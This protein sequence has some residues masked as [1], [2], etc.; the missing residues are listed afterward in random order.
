VIKINLLISLIFFVSISNSQTISPNENHIIDYLRFSQ[1]KGTFKSE[2]SFS[3]RPLNLGIG[4]IEIDSSVIN[5]R[6]YSKTILSNGKRL[7]LKILPINYNAEFSSHHPYNR[8]NGSLIPNRGYQHTISPGFFSRIGPL[9]IQLK[10]E[11]LYAQNLDYDGFWDGHYP[12]IWAE[13]YEDWN[14]IDTP[15]RFGDSEYKK[16]LWGQSNIRLNYKKLSLGLSTENIWW[17]PS[18]RN[19]IMMSNHA[20]GF[21]HIT[22]NTLSPINSAIGSFEWQF[23]T[24]KLESSGFNPPQ[25]D[26]TYAGTLLFKEKLNQEGLEDWRYF[27]GFSFTYSPKWIDG[28]SVGFIR[29]VQMYSALVKGNYWWMV[30]NPTYFP[31]FANLFRKNDKSVDYEY[32]TDQAAGIFMRWLWKSAK[33]EIYA[34]FHRNDAPQ[35]FRDLILDSD[36][37]RAITIGLQKIFKSRNNF[38]YL[39]SWEWTQLEQTSGRLLRNAGS[40][41]H[42]I[43]VYHGYTNKGEV[44]GAGIGPG[45]NSNYFSFSAINEKTKYGL[46]F[47][48]IDHDNDFYTEAFMAADDFR[49][50]W[51]DLNL[52]LNYNKKFKNFWLSS[53]LI[54]SRSLNYQWELDDFVEPY[55]HAGRDVNNFHLNIKLSYFL[56]F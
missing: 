12:I 39:F 20:R 56:N 48:I 33:A 34:E 2:V 40:W 28:F 3:L 15:E 41:Y 14:H 6:K 45:S 24:G 25:T 35:N 17:G 21:K 50:Y 4:G 49:R 43:Y 27:Q 44:I 22:F 23:V 19:S 47:E 38:D 55:Y 5:I 54:Y 7:S 46:A 53:N 8:N 32:Q 37:S 30:G 26:R 10:P 51:K 52:I 36:H 29:W 13:R 31:V 18:I 11:F 1:L 42:H 16:L 9:S